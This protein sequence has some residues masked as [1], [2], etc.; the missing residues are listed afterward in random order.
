MNKTNTKQKNKNAKKRKTTRIPPR[1]MGSELKRAYSNLFFII[2]DY[3][4]IENTTWFLYKTNPRAY[5]TIQ[6]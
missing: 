3:K 2:L 6:K 1:G 5:K 4:L